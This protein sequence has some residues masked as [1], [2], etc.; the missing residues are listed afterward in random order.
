MKRKVKPSYQLIHG[1]TIHSLRDLETASVDAVVTDP[2]YSSGGLHAG[3]RSQGVNKKYEQSG[4]RLQRPSYVGDAKDQRSWVRWC[5]EWLDECRRIAKPGAPICVFSD[6]RQ[7]PALTDALQFADWTWRGIAVWDKTEGARCV[8]GRFRAQAEY[9]VWGSSGAL[10]LRTEVG[11]LPGVFRHPVRQADKHHING[12][13]TDLMRQLVK[14][15]PP[16][17]TV[18]DPFTGSGTT[19]VAAVLEGCSFIG[20]EREPVYFDVAQQ[21]LQE[22]AAA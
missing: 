10:P 14:I 13:P 8:M 9:V 20:I 4:Q 11:V 3:D 15:C 16:G 22:A 2:P 1:E 21:R 6:W 12:K 5:H 19:G 18:L 17:G 7:L